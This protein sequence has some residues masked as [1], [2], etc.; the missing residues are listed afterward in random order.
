MRTPTSW[1]RTS[2][3]R[4]N[5][6]DQGGQRG[7]PHGRPG[8][9]EKTADEAQAELREN[10]HAT[11]NRRAAHQRDEKLSPGGAPSLRHDAC[12]DTIDT[13]HTA[14]AISY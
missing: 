12:S 13:W 3:I 2:Q 5:A 10:T 4:M 11:P 14:K 6:K 9:E 8:Y 1:G 7:T